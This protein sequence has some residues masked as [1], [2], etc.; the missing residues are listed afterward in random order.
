MTIDTDSLGITTELPPLAI[1]PDEVRRAAE[2]AA[3]GDECALDLGATVVGQVARRAAE[4]PDLVAFLSGSEQTTYA[5]L[6]RRIASARRR[7]VASGCAPGEV[8]AV[9][10]FRSVDTAVVFLALE[11]IGAVYLPLDPSWPSARL[12][13]VLTESRVVRVV[14]Y[15]RLPQGA[16]AQDELA[17][18]VARL[19]VPVVRIEPDACPALPLP[20]AIAEVG[21]DRCDDDGE[22]R[23]VYCTSGTTGVPKAALV[24]HRGMINHLWAKITDLGMTADDVLAFTSPLVFDIAI[25][26]MLIPLVLGG[27]A[28]VVDDATAAFPRRLLADL[29]RTG[30]TVVELVPT[31]VGL[32]VDEIRRGGGG[33]PSLRWVVSTGEELHPSLAERVFETMPGVGLLNSYGFTECSDDVAHHVVMPADLVGSRLPVG[34]AVI[35]STLYV[36]VE[37]GEGWRAAEPGETGELFV[38]GLPVG[39]GYV[40][41]TR[42][43]AD[44]FFRDPIDPKSPTARLYRTGDAAALRDGVLCFFGRLDRQTKISGVRIEPDEV[45]AVLNRHPGVSRSAVLVAERAGAPELVAHYVPSDRFTGEAALLEHLRATLPPAMVPNRWVVMDELP[46]SLNGKIDYRTLSRAVAP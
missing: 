33:L 37:T 25:C 19:G 4:T 42:A 14:D 1:S 45:E 34:S 3:T 43:T 46:L 24:E 2:F 28:V 38:G 40:G 8:V 7:L 41:N 29:R 35:N 32:L 11:T 21:R 18:A 20:D 30:T 10:G 39:R 36:L 13:A 6:V 12:E 27:R 17:G 26:Q 16:R 23:Y 9:Q 31:V 5:D 22:P 15:L 44:A